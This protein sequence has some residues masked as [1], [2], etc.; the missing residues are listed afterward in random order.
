[1]TVKNIK[2]SAQT[3]AIL[4]NNCAWIVTN[5]SDFVTQKGTT[6]V[7]CVNNA[8][9]YD[10]NYMPSGSWSISAWTSWAQQMTQSG[11]SPAVMSLAISTDIYTAGIV[12]YIYD[13]TIL[14]CCNTGIIGSGAGICLGADNSTIQG[15]VNSGEIRASGSGSQHAMSDVSVPVPPDWDLELWDKDG[16]TVLV[17]IVPAMQ[18]IY[19]MTPVKVFE[20]YQTAIHLQNAYDVKSKD[21]S[22]VL[23]AASQPTSV[24][25]FAGASTSA[26][27]GSGICSSI[28]NNTIVMHCTN[29]G[30]ISANGGGGIVGFANNSTIKKCKNKGDI[31]NIGAGICNIILSSNIWNCC[32][33]GNLLQIPSQAYA[34]VADMEMFGTIGEVRHTAMVSGPSIPSIQISKSA[35]II[36]ISLGANKIYNCI[37]KGSLSQSNCAGI[38]NL[39]DNDLIRRCINYGN[40]LVDTVTGNAGI[41]LQLTASILM[42]CANQGNIMGQNSG[43]VYSGM[44]GTIINCYNSGTV[45]STSTAIIRTA[46]RMYISSCYVSS[47]L[48]SA[49]E[50]F[51]VIQA[52][53]NNIIIKCSQ[54]SEATGKWSNKSAKKYLR[55]EDGAVWSECSHHCPY[56]IVKFNKEH[57]YEYKPNELHAN[58][59]T[60]QA[61]SK[62]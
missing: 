14:K 20:W 38:I 50:L 47:R 60:V 42:E 4:A 5:N 52:S 34:K 43:I 18:Q 49:N 58:I 2:I 28:H 10:P 37:N 36:G 16:K 13:G 24:Q 55:G 29:T 15:C 61:E 1:L 39:S 51:G 35:G 45:S 56:K 12:N 3:D 54:S 8:P 59:F 26:S 11:W 7:N 22:R 19:N 17:P 48:S 32:N 23:L 40:M 53:D 57:D 6:I 33:Y 62:T 44:D 46:L 27:A 31:A 30:Q 41:A 25:T 9:L 21:E